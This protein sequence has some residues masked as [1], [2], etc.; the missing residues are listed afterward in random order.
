MSEPK[1]IL[2]LEEEWDN[3]TLVPNTEASESRGIVD[4]DSLA[5]AYTKAMLRIAMTP[6]SDVD[7]TLTERGKNYGDFTDNADYAQRIKQAMRDGRMWPQMESYM[8]EALELIASKIG[9]M[10][11]GDPRYIDNWHDIAGYAALVEQRIKAGK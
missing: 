10:L 3:A 9:R 7:S 5:Q 11:S 4:S 6:R 8:Q 2:A 1:L